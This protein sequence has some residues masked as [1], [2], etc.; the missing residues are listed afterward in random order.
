[1]PLRSEEKTDKAG[2]SAVKRAGRKE[3]SERTERWKSLPCLPDS[4]GVIGELSPAAVSPYVLAGEGSRVA[5]CLVLVAEVCLSTD[6]TATLAPSIGELL[7]DMLGVAGNEDT[8]A[9][10]MMAI[11]VWML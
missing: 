9:C 1:M 7:A 11:R 2:Y 8:L 6:G 4:N 10:F 5:D 3:V